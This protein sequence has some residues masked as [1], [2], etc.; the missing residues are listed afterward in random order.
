M[1]LETVKIDIRHF[2]FIIHSD[3]FYGTVK[4]IILLFLQHSYLRVRLYRISIKVCL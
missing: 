1:N 2:R 3:Y 4:I